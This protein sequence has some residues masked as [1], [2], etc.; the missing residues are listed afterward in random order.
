M[1]PTQD[2]RT[3][4][5]IADALDRPLTVNEEAGNMVEA[6]YERLLAQGHL[7]HRGPEAARV[8]MATLPTGSEP[9]YNPI[10]TAPGVRLS[11]DETRLYILPGVP[12]ELETMFAEAVLPDLKAH[13]E[14]NTWAEDALLV[15][16]D[17]EAEVAQPLEGVAERHPDVYVKSLARPFPEATRE[18]LKV[19]AATSSSSK[20]AAQQAVEEALTDL[21]RTLEDAGFTVTTLTPKEET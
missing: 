9:L 14:L 16:C 8:K 4:A 2:D 1:G 19:I 3:L 12:E 17:D 7:A 15:H 10:G 5:A 21:R 20:S 6:H 13:F 11:H 18:G